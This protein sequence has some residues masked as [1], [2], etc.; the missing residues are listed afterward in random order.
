MVTGRDSSD[1]RGLPDGLPPKK[2]RIPHR[3]AVT[4]AHRGK[5]VKPTIRVC[6]R[7]R[8]QALRSVRNYSKK[9]GDGMEEAHEKKRKRSKPDY[10][11]INGFKRDNYDL[12]TIV[13][14]KGSKER[15]KQMAKARNQN[16]SDFIASLMPRTLIGKWK[17][18]GQ[19]EE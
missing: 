2:R 11:Y 10:E 19:E 5:A 4:N 14:P 15:I 17:K 16:M 3:L 13:L 1:G 7:V 12:V 9:G 6:V 18:K 8:S